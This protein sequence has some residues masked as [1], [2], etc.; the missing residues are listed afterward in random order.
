MDLVS[1]ALN[2]MTRSCFW[3][4]SWENNLF[5]MICLM[6][7]SDAIANGV[8]SITSHV[9]RYPWF[10]VIDCMATGKKKLE[11][12]II[13]SLLRKRKIQPPSSLPEQRPRPVNQGAPD[14]PNNGPY[15][16]EYSVYH[17]TYITEPGPNLTKCSE[18]CFLMSETQT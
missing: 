9:Q 14:C 8:Q 10:R 15:I 2:A 7:V 5:L 4:Y 17:N 3:G 18:K 6:H 1:D 11:V 13:T 12:N 16:R